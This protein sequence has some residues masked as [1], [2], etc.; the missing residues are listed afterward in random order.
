L[1]RTEVKAGFTI[2]GQ[3]RLFFGGERNLL[4]LYAT[5]RNMN[6]SMSFRR[7][8]IFALLT[9]FIVSC[10]IASGCEMNAVA[11][12]AQGYCQCTGQYVSSTGCEGDHPGEGCDYDLL[13]NYCG[14]SGHSTCYVAY[15]YSTFCENLKASRKLAAVEELPELLANKSSSAPACADPKA[16]RAW[17]RTA[18]GFP[19]STSQRSGGT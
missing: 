17:L 11:V 5:Q 18:P 14:S 10:G 13:G 16:F 7:D 1:Q 6:C 12:P 19:A 8:R 3:N 9:W 15:A 2:S 4:L